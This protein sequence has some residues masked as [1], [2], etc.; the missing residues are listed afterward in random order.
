VPHISL[1]SIL[2]SHGQVHTLCGGG[3]TVTRRPSL[4]RTLATGLLLYVGSLVCGITGPGVAQ[5][6]ATAAS[7]SGSA[8]IAVRQ[9]SAD[10]EELIAEADRQIAAGQTMTPAGDNAMDT[11]GAIIN[12]ISDASRDELALIRKI[13]ERFAVRAAAADAAGRRQEAENY[14][15]LGRV[16]DFGKPEDD[17]ATKKA[18]NA[19]AD[20][21]AAPAS[22]S[23]LSENRSPSPAGPEGEQ[24]QLLQAGV[25]PPSGADSRFDQVGRAPPLAATTEVPHGTAATDPDAE[26]RDP[27][28]ARGSDSD[29]PPPTIMSRPAE[30]AIQRDDTVPRVAPQASGRAQASPSHEEPTQSEPRLSF[31]APRI[32]MPLSVGPRSEEPRATP[33]PRA[34]GS[35]V[36]RSRPPH[37]TAREASLSSNDAVTA[38]C[39]AITIRVQLGEEPSDAERAYL[40]RGCQPR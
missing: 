18:A 11:F 29:M 33:T 4:G 16:F 8:P 3:D 6:D 2:M 14:L 34:S 38:R 23:A 31:A 27:R 32:T 26:D 19:S 25:S 7:R 22:G 21:G 5:P 39:R 37:E 40:R 24:E 20:T 15:L 12:R 35:V 28:S 30:R 36:G 17:S 1:I 9:R 10:L 13:P